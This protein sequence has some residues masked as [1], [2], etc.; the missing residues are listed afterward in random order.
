M[1]Y[2][3]LYTKNIIELDTKPA[4]GLSAYWVLDNDDVCRPVPGWTIRA[5]SN[6]YVGQLFQAHAVSCKKW[7][8]Q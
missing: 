6:P 3:S 5:K 1:V 8:R 2:T 7:K 4:E